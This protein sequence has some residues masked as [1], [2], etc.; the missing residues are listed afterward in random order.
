MNK[1]I[2]GAASAALIATSSANASFVMY[3][4][5][6]STVGIDRIVQDDTLAGALT[7]IGLTTTDDF[8][9]TIGVVSYSGGF[10]DFLV[11]VTTGLSKPVLNAPG[12]MFDLNS[13]T[14]SGGTGT[15]TIGLTDTDFLRDGGAGFLNFSIG[16]TTDGTV[17][18]SAYMDVANT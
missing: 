2:L 3:L 4:D 18:A 9:S 6:S 17:S 5:D 1:L 10:G 11:N 14:V 7:S 8:D 16:G 15:L 13:V 12:T